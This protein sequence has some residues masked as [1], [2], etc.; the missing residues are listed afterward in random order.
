M[1]TNIDIDDKVMAA[2]MKGGQFK[3]KREAVEAGLRLI[4]QR[5]H[6]REVLKWRGKLH[7][8]DQPDPA[9][10]ATQQAPQVAETKARYPAKAARSHAR[11]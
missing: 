6:A 8:D 3:T 4:A 11:R 5:N 7:W 1:R 9:A 2:A 10:A